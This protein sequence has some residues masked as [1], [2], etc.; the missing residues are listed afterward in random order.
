MKETNNP[1]AKAFPLWHGLAWVGSLGLGLSVFLS[2]A[3]KLH[4]EYHWSEGI[5]ATA[6]FTLYPEQQDWWLYL[7]ALLIVPVVTFLGYRL[8]V[9]GCRWLDILG[10]TLDGSEIA[11][12]TSGYLVWWILPLT[13]IF[14]QEFGPIPVYGIGVIFV[15]V[16][17][18]LFLYCWSRK[19]ASASPLEAP[20]PLTLQAALVILGTAVGISVLRF[21]LDAPLLGFPVRV[22]LITAVGLWGIWWGFSYWLHR[23]IGQ[24]WRQVAASAAVVCLP[25]SLLLLQ[26]VLWWRVSQAGVVVSRVTLWP[27]G[28]GLVGIVGA[29]TVGTVAIASRHLLK[30]SSVDWEDLFFRCFFAG[31]IPLLMYAMVYDPDINGALDLFHEGESVAPAQA[32]MA[33]GL[34][35]KDVVFVH[36]FLRD[37]GVALGAFGLLGKS[38]ASLRIITQ[39]LSPLALVFTYYLA[40]VCLGR[41]W[42]LIYSALALTGFLPFLW[43][44]RVVPALAAFVFL[45]RYFQS[46]RLV[47]TLLSGLATFCALATSFDVGMVALSACTATLAVFTLFEWRSVKLGPLLEYSLPMLI[48][49]AIIFIFFMPFSAWEPFWDWHREILT[50]YRDWNGM[51]FPIALHDLH[52][53]WMNFLSPLV[54]VVTLVVLGSAFFRKR[55]NSRHWIVLLLL[56]GNVLLYNRGVVSGQEYSS[57]LA[58]G[59]HLAPLLLLLLFQSSSLTDM[60]SFKYVLPAL[61]LLGTVVPTPLQPAGVPTLVDLVNALPKKNRIEIPEGWMSPALNRVG[62]IYLPRE[63]A[64][65]LEAI[66]A[67]L[68]QADSFWDFSDHGALYFLSDHTGPTRFYATH[69]V[70]TLDNQREV[71]ADLKDNPPQYIIFRS[72]SVWD[73][74][75]G[76]DRTLRNSLVSEYILRAYRFSDQIGGYSILERGKAEDLPASLTFGVDLGFVPFLWGRDY[77]PSLVQFHPVSVMEWE[78]SS[79]LGG[80]GPGADIAQSEVVEDGWLVLTGGNDPGLENSEISLDPWSI[81]YL[82]LQLQVEPPPGAEAIRGQLFWRSGDGGFSENRSV[83]FDVFP[84]GQ[85]HLYLLRLASFPGWLWSD[86]ITGLR[87]DIGSMPDVHVKIVSMEFLAVDEIDYD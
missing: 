72:G 51:P 28:W 85:E 84:D 39:L 26:G 83:T 1:E 37:P 22:V 59:S 54:S 19:R 11:I 31:V 43:D 79:G 5:T 7:L 80:W 56:V 53:L 58:A 24:P 57:A 18:M 76:V 40:L 46:R 29:I 48:C 87:L 61:L 35:Y 36:G 62:S 21:P 71:I 42:A 6:A 13:Y 10:S 30:E 66:T 20:P 60:R 38:M 9:Y 52:A 23:L 17:G 74:I 47:W 15:I 82:V 65:S 73:N 55:L 69:H 67:F 3:S 50:V 78:F 64:E 70:I 68:G 2:L 34:P 25:L 16:Q 12:L 27:A 41:K 75:A 32:L 4:F 8:W 44:W 33:G 49:L 14:A 63:Q 86:H 77:A 81:T 45:A